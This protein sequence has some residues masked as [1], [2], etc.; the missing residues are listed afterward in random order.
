MR[1]V[2]LLPERERAQ[3]PTAAGG[4]SYVVVGVLAALLLAVFAYVMT[5]NQ[6]NSRT[7]DVAKAEAE[8]TRAETRAASFGPFQ[9]FAQIKT[10]RLTSVKTLAD[11]RFDWERLMRELALVLPSGS[12]LTA[13]T[14]SS[15]DAAS[16]TSTP[17]APP[18]APG[19]TTTAPPGTP[20]LT[21]TGCATSQRRVAVMLVRLRQ[22]HRAA[23]V[24]LVD[25]SQGETSG[26]AGASA[27]TTGTT[28]C[29]GS[30]YLFNVA[31][32]FGPA[33]PT[34]LED[35]DPSVPSSLGG[36]A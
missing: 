16:A 25:S 13:V 11:T 26:E 19:A 12:S 33:V 15:G 34:E 23:D 4:S 28:G 5:S 9:Q 22:L 2:N 8:A 24:Q 10:D 7:G 27:P 20:T 21:L 18:P 14:A 36:G 30:D 32:T 29:F 17:T 31:V 3:A 1:P 6:I 35:E